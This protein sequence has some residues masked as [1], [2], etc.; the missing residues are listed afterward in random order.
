[1]TMF[2]GQR[3]KTLPIGVTWNPVWARYRASTKLDD[4][5]E[6]SIGLFD[7]IDDALAAIG[8]YQHFYNKDNNSKD[9]VPHGMNNVPKKETI[10]LIKLP[11][12]A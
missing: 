10:S 11:T 9:M 2:V 4:G 3:E 7:S 6:I 12:K 8:S 1:M 5:K